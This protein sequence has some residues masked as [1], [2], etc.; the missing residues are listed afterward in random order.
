VVD[1]ALHHLGW[2]AAQAERYLVEQ[3][4]LAPEAAA[5]EVRRYIEYP[6]QALS[7]AVGKIGIL[8]L[9]AGER[10]RL[11]PAFDPRAFH[12]ALLRHGAA[13]LSVVASQVRAARTA[14]EAA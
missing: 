11:G 4:G 2:P 9:R 13:P 3:A 7:Y 1:T 5:S 12:A 6:A 8:E 10:K 14:P